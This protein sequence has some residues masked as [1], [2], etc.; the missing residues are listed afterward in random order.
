MILKKIIKNRGFLIL[1]INKEVLHNNSH[2][3]LFSY[4]SKYVSKGRWLDFFIFHIMYCNSF[5]WPAIARQYK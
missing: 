4:I 5:Q 1:K 3:V 2:F